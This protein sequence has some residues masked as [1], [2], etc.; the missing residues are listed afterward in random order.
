M[1]YL[2]NS[3]IKYNII[4]KINIFYICLILFENSFVYKYILIKQILFRKDILFP[5]LIIL[6]FQYNRNISIILREMNK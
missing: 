5:T 4:F 3:N 2:F 6:S 1:L